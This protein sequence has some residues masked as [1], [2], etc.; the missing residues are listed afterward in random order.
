MNEIYMRYSHDY[1]TNNQCKN[2]K[3]EIVQIQ[4]PNQRDCGTGTVLNPSTLV[5][6][7]DN[8]DKCGEGT[9]YDSTINKCVAVKMCDS[10]TYFDIYSNKCLS[11][12]CG[13]DLPHLQ[14]NE[15]S[16]ILREENGVGVCKPIQCDNSTAFELSG[17]CI[18]FNELNTND[19]SDTRNYSHQGKEGN[20]IWVHDKN[21]L[22]GEFRPI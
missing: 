2:R 22:Q 7:T 12:L 18:S 14:Q 19:E 16:T 5:C 20:T 15:I 11:S 21:G 6:E 10:G 17:T 13:G 8:S 3:P 1:P 4:N 9:M